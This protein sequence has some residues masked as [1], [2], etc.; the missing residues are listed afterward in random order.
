[1][2]TRRVSVLIGRPAVCGRSLAESVAE[3]TRFSEYTHTDAYTDGIS[4]TGPGSEEG[5]SCESRDQLLSSKKGVV[6]HP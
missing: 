2:A 1:M 4:Y 3:H 5:P 6:C